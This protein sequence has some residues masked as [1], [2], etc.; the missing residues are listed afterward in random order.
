[1]PMSYAALMIHVDADGELGRHV[2]I[3]G[4]LAERL[5]AHVIGVAG[6]APMSVFLADAA[7]AGASPPAPHLQ[8][9]KTLLDQKGEQLRAVL[10]ATGRTIEWRSVLDYPTDV[11]AREARSADLIIVGPST[12]TGDP[13]RTLDIG[14]LVLTAGRPVLHV[15]SQASL[16]L[17]RAAIAWK[18]TREARRAVRDALPLL[19]LSE[20]V[21]VIDVIEQ[22]GDH[23]AERAHDVARYL[24]RHGV[25]TVT[26]RAPLAEVTVI[27]T[28]LHM[29]QVENIDL[30]VAGAYGHSRLGEWMFGGVTR[31]LLRQSPVCCLLSH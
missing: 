21:L 24:A 31:D 15:P 28:L 22:E 25:E 17:K 9:M 12:G 13:F 30:L 14:R 7:R 4:A 10:A 29:I 11:V 3:A 8:D 19:Q 26:G 6:W 18:D 23:G 16:P 5:R 1:M 20:S 27:D 2:E